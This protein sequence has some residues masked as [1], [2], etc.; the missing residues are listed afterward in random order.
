ML[1]HH[2]VKDFV[3]PH[4]MFPPCTSCNYVAQRN[5]FFITSQKTLGNIN[6]FKLQS[7]AVLYFNIFLEGKTINQTVYQDW[8]SETVTPTVPVAKKLSFS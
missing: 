5:V 4:G 2:T 8:G 1:L 3:C 7:K 6:I